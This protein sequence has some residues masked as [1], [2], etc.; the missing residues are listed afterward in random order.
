M[1]LD[2]G[3]VI[4][5][6]ECFIPL[7]CLFNHIS[8]YGVASAW[9][10]TREMLP[11][12]LLGLIYVVFG[13]ILVRACLGVLQCAWGLAQQSSPSS[14]ATAAAGQVVLRAMPQASKRLL[15]HAHHLHVRV[16]F[17][18]WTRTEKE[19]TR[20]VKERPNLKLKILLQN[21]TNSNEN[22]TVEA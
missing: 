15:S 9:T 2:P 4:Y 10:Q 1:F 11:K 21:F 22:R 12:I 16:P 6:L 5:S 14:A 3:G 13:G 7:V 20:T 8:C 18:A 19:Q 17:D